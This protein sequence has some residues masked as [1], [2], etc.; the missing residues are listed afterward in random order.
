M[1]VTLP[2]S[3]QIRR[4]AAIQ[5]KAHTGWH[6]ARLPVFLISQMFHVKQWRLYE[7]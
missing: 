7:L 2:I 5:L 3:I 4:E 6:A 1:L